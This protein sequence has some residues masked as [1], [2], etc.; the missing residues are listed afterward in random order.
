MTTVEIVSLVGLGS[1]I[2]ER[3]S[4]QF[5]A[6]EWVSRLVESLVADLREEH[7]ECRKELARMNAILVEIR[8]DSE[9]AE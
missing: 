3:I 5:R 7:A 2:V 8:I 9:P 4:Y 6:K 1:L